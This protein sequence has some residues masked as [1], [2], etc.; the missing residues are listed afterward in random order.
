M[1]GAGMRYRW[2]W[3][4]RPPAAE[5]GTAQGRAGEGRWVGL[6]QDERWT[7]AAQGKAGK[8]KLGGAGMGG[9]G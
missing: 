7:G 5:T 1:G 2:G 9:A 6:G 8:R 3:V 4:E